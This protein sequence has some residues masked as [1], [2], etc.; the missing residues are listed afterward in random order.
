QPQPQPQQIPHLQGGKDMASEDAIEVVAKFGEEKDGSAWA[1]LEYYMENN[2]RQTEWR[3]IPGVVT[4]ADK[5]DAM[6][7]AEA[8]AVEL[9]DLEIQQLQAAVR[10]LYEKGRMIKRLEF[11]T[12]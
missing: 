6:A 4:G 12:T 1:T 9:S 7:K 2:P 3:R 11:P 8:I 10:R 5:D